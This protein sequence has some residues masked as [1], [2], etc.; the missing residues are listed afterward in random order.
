MTG[1]ATTFAGTAFHVSGGYALTA[2]HV[3]GDRTTGRLNGD[4]IVLTFPSHMTKASVL[5]F[6]QN[7][8]WA[9]LHCKTAPPKK[10]LPLAEHCDRGTGWRAYGFPDVHSAG[11]VIDGHVVEAQGS[12]EGVLAIQLHCN[13]A[14][15][16]AISGLSGSP[17]VVEGS[18][19]GLL[20]S[21]IMMDGKNVTG[22]IWACPVAE[23][24][25]ACER[26]L[27]NPDPYYGLPGI[28]PRPLPKSPFRYLERYTSEHAE[29]F[30]GRG[31]DIRRLYE[32]L[33]DPAMPPVVLLYGESGV[34]KS[35]L[36]EAGLI[37]RLE[38]DFNISVRRRTP[39][40]SLTSDLREHLAAIS[41]RESIL[42]LDQ[43]EETFL[44]DARAGH[45][46]VLELLTAVGDELGRSGSSTLVKLVLGFRKEWL[47]EIEQCATDVGTIF[48]K[49]HVQPLG[50]Q[51]VIEAVRGLTLS[52][53]LR[54]FYE[55]SVEDGVP[56]AIADYVCSDPKSAVAP[57]LAILLTELWNAGSDTKRDFSL[58]T[59]Q[60]LIR[61]GQHLQD[62][63]SRQMASVA[64][65]HED[66]ADSGLLLDVL[67]Y[68]TTDVG[69][70]ADRGRTETEA[71]YPNRE[72]SIL[73]T[74]LRSHFL[75]SDGGP[76][77]TRLAHDTLARFVRAQYDKSAK[78][79]Q[80]ARRILDSRADANRALAADDLK[81]VE[82]GLEGMRT[83]N[84]DERQL[85][86][87]SRKK[88]SILRLIV[89]VVV[90][91]LVG[92]SVMIVDQ[93]AMI[94]AQNAD[95]EKKNE[96]ITAQLLIAEADNGRSIDPQ[97]SLL[98]A[99]EAIKRGA[100]APGEEVLRR[101]LEQ[102]MGNAMV[103]YPRPETLPWQLA[104]IV[105]GG[106]YWPFAVVNNDGST[107][108]YDLY[109]QHKTPRD[110]ALTEKPSAIL[111]SPNRQT[112]AIGDQ[113]QGVTF[114]DL[115]AMNGQLKVERDETGNLLPGAINH[116]SFDR[117]ARW[118]GA[119][120]G[121]ML[122]TVVIWHRTNSVWEKFCDPAL[123]SSQETVVNISGNG[124]WAAVSSSD[125]PKFLLLGLTGNRCSLNVSPR[126]PAVTAL[127]TDSEGKTVFTGGASGSIREWKIKD[128]TTMERGRLLVGATGEVD[129]LI[130][131]PDSRWLM[132]SA[133]PNLSEKGGGAWLWDLTS[134]SG[135]S[136][137]PIAI[138]VDRFVGAAFSGSS[139]WLA[140]QGD[141]DR[142]VQL[143]DLKSSP[144]EPSITFAGHDDVV[145]AFAFTPDDS[146]LVAA[147][148]DGSIRRLN[149]EEGPG[150]TWSKPLDPPTRPDG[151][152]LSCDGRRWAVAGPGKLVRVWE[153]KPG[154]DA[155]Q[156]QEIK[157]RNAVDRVALGCGGL[158][159]AAWS[160]NSMSIEF[161]DEG[162]HHVQ[163]IAAKGTISSIAIGS[164]RLAISTDQS[165]E[166]IENTT[167]S[168][169]SVLADG[170]SLSVMAFDRG[171]A[172]LV[173][174]REGYRPSIGIDYSSE[175]GAKPPARD[176]PVVRLWQVATGKGPFSYSVEKRVRSV[177]LWGGN[178]IFGA[179]GDRFGGNLFE[180]DATLGEAPLN[181][182]SHKTLRYKEEATAVAVSQDGSLHAA[183]IA[184]GRT[185][186]RVGHGKFVALPSAPDRIARLAFTDDGRWLV[187]V[188]EDGRLRF[189]VVRTED[190]LE[191]AK[192][193]VG[194]N[195]SCQEW[196]RTLGERDYE[197]TFSDLPSGCSGSKP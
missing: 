136:A 187:A 77:T 108:I 34:G 36:L 29:I 72:I 85:L 116:L 150:E 19:V 76:G 174:A 182:V 114:V 134:R 55:L 81:I 82:R 52:G 101:I 23:I 73:L 48:S 70:A 152:A 66:A 35:S 41:G 109:S 142:R 62:F 161:W 184:D 45:Q 83:L 105:L 121:S 2:F 37:P 151:L 120:S 16:A 9:L 194:R 125:S 166:L 32:L 79:G 153:L 24:A 191:Q 63:L 67:I 98:L 42:M 118:L 146:A 137:Q 196:E 143:W 127:A 112:L 170:A 57:T 148:R 50:R 180:L 91:C 107:S 165:L 90:L 74:S 44:S 167:Q 39:E 131:S 25:R 59:L 145:I 15:G 195:L 155:V 30:F 189:W 88:R 168:Q 84:D 172:W 27:P 14:A 18:V 193:R 33:T 60:T 47:A 58:E 117:N 75:L 99:V 11:M 1:D 100:G 192:A 126:E 156:P 69:T 71:R 158:A 56:E 147:A 54:N 40:H 183:A 97:R 68:H 113:R 13:Q 171:G 111:I 94:V 160:S 157:T 162:L 181:P 96:S 4:S 31:D 185:Y 140:T 188:T 135:P 129:L 110:L 65:A 51:N 78:P 20:R 169:R 80:R 186:I 22:T 133:S 128:A 95:L 21:A 115:G 175:E 6:N 93:H 61:N 177:A 10:G 154:S 144:K 123:A 173:G 89:C 46:E 49:M 149:L 64:K 132:A 176:P 178:I 28:R 179:G 8:D 130:V 86:L 7:A 159:M 3:I 106:T 104:S 103:P 141:G 102:R 43:V 138:G 197:M 164:G 38:L 53:R 17:C 26:W 190:L 122:G 139:R 163:E 92:L 87:R 12:Y 5:S 119:T 124:D